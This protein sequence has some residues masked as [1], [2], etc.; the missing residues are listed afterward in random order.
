MSSFPIPALMP[1]QMW[2]EAGPPPGTLYS[3]CAASNDRMASLLCIYQGRKLL[4][5]PQHVPYTTQSASQANSCSTLGNRQ[6]TKDRLSTV[7][8][9]GRMLSQR[10]LPAFGLE[11]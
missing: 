4:S 11:F 7:S 2:A 1:E 5:P 9:N 6:Y 3:W 8:Q 10:N